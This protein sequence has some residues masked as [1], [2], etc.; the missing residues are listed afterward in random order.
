MVSV[1][2][3]KCPG[4]WQPQTGTHSQALCVNPPV[5]KASLLGLPGFKEAQSLTAAPG[6]AQR[7]GT[8]EPL[9]RTA[10]LVG[11][12]GNCPLSSNTL[13]QMLSS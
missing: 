10:V 3:A 2:G 11:R 5:L 4:L 12:V 7:H 8:E 9:L 13:S 1:V 6:E